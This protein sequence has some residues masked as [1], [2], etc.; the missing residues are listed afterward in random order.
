MGRVPVYVPSTT[1]HN[2][3]PTVKGSYIGSQCR[4]YDGGWI[5]QW[6][7]GT[8]SQ[9]YPPPLCRSRSYSHLWCQ[10]MV[11]TCRRTRVVHKGRIMT[12][13]KINHWIM[14][15][16]SC[17]RVLDENICFLCCNFSVPK[18]A[19]PCLVTFLRFRQEKKE[20]V[21]FTELF[22]PSKAYFVPIQ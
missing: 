5:S 6:E 21:V 3:K 9:F 18:C 10:G 16:H 4:N 15:I 22:S 17:W 14:E 7:E 13:T 1:D 19:V 20:E 8:C 2:P 11:T 12:V